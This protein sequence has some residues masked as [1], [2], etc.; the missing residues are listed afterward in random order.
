MVTRAIKTLPPI[1]PNA[2]LEQ[3]YRRT[4]DRLVAEMQKSIAY[5]LKASYRVNAP[6]MAAD[7]SPANTLRQ[8]IRRLARRWQKRFDEAAPELAR[9]F[10]QAN[11]DRS[12][13]ALTAILKK[14]GFSVDLKLTRQM[15]NV[16]QASMGEQVGLIKSIAQQYLTQ[17]EGLVLRS[18]Q[19]GRALAELTDELED[20][21][22]ITRRR[23]A[24]IARDQNNKATAMLNKARQRELG[25]T[26]A[27]WVHSHAGN[28]PR[29]TH[30]AAGRDKVIYDVDE[31]WYDPAVGKHI[32][33][34]TEINCR[35][36]S[37]PVIPRVGIHQ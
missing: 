25:I 14:G 29:P 32:W 30:V 3:L 12:D 33:P 9:Y 34:G 37:R 16:L 24:L 27:Q 1:H 20:R 18:A 13:R 28:Q 35:C 4:L 15:R 7:E 26:Q 21:Y 10:A 5:W 6:K 22:A 17:V 36:V 23:A 19:E 8:A 31:G 11:Y 2:G